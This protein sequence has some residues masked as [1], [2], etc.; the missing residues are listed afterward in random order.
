MGM[1]KPGSRYIPTLMLGLSAVMLIVTAPI[2]HLALKNLLVAGFGLLLVA[3][4]YLRRARSNSDLPEKKISGYLKG[5]LIFLFGAAYGLVNSLSLGW[6]WV[7][8]VPLTIVTSIGAYLIWL[9]IR[10]GHSS[11]QQTRSPQG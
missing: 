6:E 5:G 3:Y 2:T 1:L 10:S 11:G 4:F 7:D 8:L 9:G